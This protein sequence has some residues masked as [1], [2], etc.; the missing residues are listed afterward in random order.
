MQSVQ[1]RYTRNF[2]IKYRKS[3]HLF[4]GRYKAIL[5]EKDSYFLGLTAYI[6]LNPVRAGLVS[7]PFQY[8]WSSYRSYMS[9]GKESLVD[10]NFLLAQFSRKKSSARRAYNHFVKSYIDWGHRKDFYELK[11]QRFLGKEEFVED[12]HRK[13]N[14]RLPTVYNISIGEI[15]SQISSILHMDSDLFYSQT[16]NHD[17]AWGSAIVGYFGRKLGRYENRKI[18]DYFNRDP[19][20]ISKGIRR[21]EERL[22]KD[23]T[24]ANK[25]EVLEQSLIYNKKRKIVN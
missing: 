6:H 3:G 11:D 5:C 15:V 9:G 12:I 1:F 21:L 10:R 2:N 25:M 8:Q 20:V 17:G 13:I 24:F 19:V 18:A 4:Q 7:D 23:K 22:R 14:E 16:R